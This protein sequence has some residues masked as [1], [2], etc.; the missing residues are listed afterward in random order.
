MLLT[1]DAHNL[2]EFSA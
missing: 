1:I 2:F